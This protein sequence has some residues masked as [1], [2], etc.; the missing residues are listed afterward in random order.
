[1]AYR[2]GKGKRKR[3][4]SRSKKRRAGGSRKGART[5]RIVVD[6]TSHGA[7]GGRRIARRVTF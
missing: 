4:A 2:K 3:S 1:M 5:I 7:K 6:S